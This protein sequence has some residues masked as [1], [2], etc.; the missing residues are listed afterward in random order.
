MPETTVDYPSI[1]S[2]KSISDLQQ[3]LNHE[4]SLLSEWFK[5]NGLS[6]NIDKTL[7]I[8]FCASNA[9]SIP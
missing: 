5:A 1:Y 2:S 8:L 3:V 7:Y 9:R 6:L 4:M